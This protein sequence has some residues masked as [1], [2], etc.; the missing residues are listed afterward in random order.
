MI[1]RIDPRS[2]VPPYEQIRA[3]VST[4]VQ[5]GVLPDGSRLPAIRQLA[6]DLRLAS[7]TVARAYRE[8]EGEGTVMT[9]GRHGT[10]VTAGRRPA[11][12]AERRRR[13][14]QAAAAFAVEAAHHGAEVDQAVDAVR[15]AFAGLTTHRRPA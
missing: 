2:P 6:K 5:G 7:G 15:R 11:P 8:L 9:Q 1:L 13:V 10:V 14:D 4:M 3:Q 12:V